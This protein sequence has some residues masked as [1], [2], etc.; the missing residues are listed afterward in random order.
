M[1]KVDDKKTAILLAT[2]S[3][4]SDNG[5]HGTSI[6]K[7]AARAGVSAGIIY[8]Y[9][10]NKDELITEL[11]LEL[12]QRVVAA[13]LENHDP[14]SPLR[15]QIRQLWGKM[16]LFFLNN[17]E[18]TGFMTQFMYSPYFTP[19]VQARGA[20]YYRPVSTLYDRAKEERIIKDLPPAVLGA[21]AVDV[22]SA[23]VQR[24]K[25][26]QLELTDEVVERVV[27]SLWEAIRL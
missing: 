6:S 3:L 4:V 17:P 24:Q 26:G 11:Y 2:L 27:E 18:V 13:Q 14:D 20:S 12:K 22:P 23:L 16:I 5:F 15:T 1:T 25:T 21:F 8:H 10:K 7:V 19:E 9:F